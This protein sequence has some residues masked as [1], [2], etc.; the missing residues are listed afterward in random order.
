MTR[1]VEVTVDPPS[2]EDVYIPPVRSDSCDGAIS[3]G[4]E[5]IMPA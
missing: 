4:G 1:S 5:A 2:A 3:V